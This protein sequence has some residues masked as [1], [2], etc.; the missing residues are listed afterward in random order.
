MT[1]HGWRSCCMVHPHICAFPATGHFSVFC[2]ALSQGPSI[3]ESPFC[4]WFGP[5][6]FQLHVR[7]CWQAGCGFCLGPGPRVCCPTLGSAGGAGCPLHMGPGPRVRGG[8]IRV[9]MQRRLPF[10]HGIRAQGLRGLT[11][12]STGSAGCPFHMASRPRVCGAS[13]Q[14]QQAAQAA[15]FRMASGPRVLRSLTPGSTG[16]AGCPSRMAS[17]PRE[18]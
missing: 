7:V 13:H 6:V 5:R 9:F 18:P 15:L 1:W 17:G 16:S 12:G 8:S 4:M 11:S 14:G 10:P 2:A 3:A